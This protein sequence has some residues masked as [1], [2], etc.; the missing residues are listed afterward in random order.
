MSKHEPEA[1]ER[2]F[3][4]FTI[5]GTPVPE[6]RPRAAIRGGHATVYKPE[7]SRT[8]QSIVAGEAMQHRPE[9]LLE[10]ALVLKVAFFLPRPKSLPKKVN[11]HV[12][13]PDLDNLTKTIKDGMSSI[14]FHDDSQIVHLEAYKKYDNTPRVE[15]LVYRVADSWQHAYI[16]FRFPQEA[17]QARLDGFAEER[18]WKVV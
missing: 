10:G 16:D 17:A 9:K 13:R 3:V 6:A 15:I 5:F 7:K 2:G 8:W 14:I 1:V 11:H 4:Q 18:G 12:K